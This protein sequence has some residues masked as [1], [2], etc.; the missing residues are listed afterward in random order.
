M[1]NLT[2]HPAT[3]EQIAAGVI[4][5]PADARRRLHSLLTFNELPGVEDIL[6]RADEIA[7]IAALHLM[8]PRAMIGGAPWLMAP[9]AEALRKRGIDPMF[10]FSVREA[11]EQ[12]MAD[13]SVKKE[14]IFRHAGFVVAV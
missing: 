5:L 6:A 10:A 11:K 13:G 8:L 12:I 7:S 1:I 3:A 14:A 9:L 4:D 2:Q